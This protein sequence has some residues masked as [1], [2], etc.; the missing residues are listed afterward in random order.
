M[1]TER[2]PLDAADIADLEGARLL[3]DLEQEGFR[4]AIDIGPWGLFMVVCAIQ[5][6][7]RHPG[8]PEASLKAWREVG[9]QMIAGMP[10][11]RLRAALERGWDPDRDIT[12]A[13]FVDHGPYLAQESKP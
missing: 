8:I 7:S 3:L 9:D 13:A 11:K 5:L 6:A 1:T 12:P 4:V 10:V 2:L